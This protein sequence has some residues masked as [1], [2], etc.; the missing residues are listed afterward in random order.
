MHVIRTVHGPALRQGRRFVR[1]WLDCGRR[2][3]GAGVR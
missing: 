3:D 2:L 1:G